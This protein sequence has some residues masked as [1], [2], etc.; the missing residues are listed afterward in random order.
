MRRRVL[1]LLVVCAIRLGAQATGATAHPV[2]LISIDGLKPEYVLQADEHGLKI[3]NLR[4]LVAHGAHASGVIG[5][6]PTVTYPS[7]T[8]LVTG[9]APARHGIVSNTTFDPL[10][11]NQEG[12]YWYASDIRVHLPGDGTGDSRGAVCRR[13]RRALAR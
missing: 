9:V 13:R 4:G 8:T 2:V 1:S 5:V 7:H 6:V 12:W 3:P 10:N 11:K